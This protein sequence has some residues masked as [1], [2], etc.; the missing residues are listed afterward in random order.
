[1][2]TDAPSDELGRLLNAPDDETVDRLV[3]LL[4]D[5]LRRMARREMAGER[6][7]HT[8]DPTALANETYLRLADSHGVTERGRTYLLGAAARAMR[9]VLIDHA[10]SRGRQK[11]GGD[12]RRVTLKAANEPA[13][14]AAELLEIDDALERLAE[15]APRQALVVEARYFGGMTVEETAALLDV[16]PRTLKSDWAFARAWM[17]RSMH[18]GEDV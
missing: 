12:L 2:G 11:R 3:P 6:A 5:E 9:R 16:S 15:L 14:L 1:M 8:L 4:Y 7:G 17:N 18:G 10:R 13:E